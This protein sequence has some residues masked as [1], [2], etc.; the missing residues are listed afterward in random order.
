VFIMSSN[1]NLTLE[2]VLLVVQLACYLG[3]QVEGRRWEIFAVTELFQNFS[4]IN[5]FSEKIL[6]SNSVTEQLERWCVENKIG[7]GRVVAL[8]ERQAPREPIDGDSLDALTGYRSPGGSTGFRRVRLAS[9]G[10]VLV[11]ALNWYFPDNLTSEM[12]RELEMTDVPFGRAIRSLR[13]RRRTFAVWRA[14]PEQLMS[15][16]EPI[17]PATIAFEHRAVVYRTDNIPL[18]I[19]HERFRIALFLRAP[20][21]AQDGRSKSYFG[22]WAGALSALPPLST[23]FL[24]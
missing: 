21:P 10:L 12:C 22:F 15:C 23:H 3:E 5:S 11:D 4:S 18:A 8:C 17:D 19:V 16:Q 24:K 13:P 2:H 7:D 6:R 20:E 1:D 9:A 14:T